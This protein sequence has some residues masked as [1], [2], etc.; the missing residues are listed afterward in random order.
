MRQ[1]RNPGPTKIDVSRGLGAYRSGTALCSEQ[2]AELREL[3][4]SR[5][6]PAVVGLRARTVLW[7]VEGRRRKDIAELAGVAPLTVARCK[8]RYVERGVAGLEDKRRGEPRTQVP[9]RARARVIALTRNG[10]AR[11][12]RASHT[13]RRERWLT[14]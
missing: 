14:T 2:I 11:G 13:G 12:F 8:A 6:V 10:P 3:V 9:P 4:G 7:S 1:P 5:D